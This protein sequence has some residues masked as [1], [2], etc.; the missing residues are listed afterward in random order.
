MNPIKPEWIKEFFVK[1]DL[2]DVL[3]ESIHID[4]YLSP[5]ALANFLNRK[6]ADEIQEPGEDWTPT[7]ENIN[8]LPKGMKEYICGLETL[9]DPQYVIRENLIMKDT[10]KQ[11]EA[12]IAKEQK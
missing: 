12:K 9:C 4:G 11:L 5:Q 10:I 8:A 6:M 1:N 7:A 3:I 2:N